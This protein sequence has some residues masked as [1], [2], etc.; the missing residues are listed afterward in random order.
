MDLHLIE[1]VKGF[2]CTI[3]SPDPLPA[4]VVLEHGYV[5]IIS[6]KYHHLLLQL[7]ILLNLSEMKTSRSK[8][9]R[10]A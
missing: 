8:A 5:T 2:L 6:R 10:P 4:D 7:R 9:S 1:S 3:D